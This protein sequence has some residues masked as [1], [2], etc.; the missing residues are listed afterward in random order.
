ML[1]PR[2]RAFVDTSTSPQRLINPDG[3]IIRVVANASDLKPGE[4]AIRIK[5]YPG[6]IAAKFQ[7]SGQV[8]WIGELPPKP[9]A[10][11]RQS[12]RDSL[13]FALE[14]GDDGR[15]GLRLPQ[16]G[17]VH[18][19]LGCWTTSST[20]PATVVMPTGT[21]KTETM[22]AL[23]AAGQLE[24]LLV[25]VPSDVLRTQIAAKFESLG[26]LQERGVIAVNAMRPVVGRL[27]QGFSSADAARSFVDAC[28]VVVTT[29]AAL[30]ASGP[31]A[32][33]TILSSFSHLFIDEAH[34]VEAAT[35]QRIRDSFAGKPIL[36]FTATPF[37]EDGRRL[38]GRIV[39]SYP[40]REAQRHGYFS[41]I[42]YVSIVDFENQDRAIAARAVEQLRAD[43]AAGLDHL[44]M[45]RVMRIG[46]IAD[47][48]QIYAE[49]APDF[50][51]V[52]LHSKLSKRERQSA[53]DR[54]SRRKSRI[55]ICVDML[56]E[57]FDLPSLKVA[58]IHDVHKS[59]GVTLQFIGRLARVAGADIGEAT[60]VAAR[61]EG[62]Y[63][64]NLRRLYSEDPD[65]NLII[66]DLSE[67]AVGQEDAISQF[68]AG[69]RAVP[70]EVT[71][72]N[73]EPKMSTVVY[74]TRCEIWRPQAISN[75][76]PE[77]S[78]LAQP[79]VNEL[80]HVAWFIV[81]AQT[82]V[83]WGQ[84]ETLSDV[85]YDLY[86]LY[87]DNN[88][89]LLY[90]NGS[91]N[92]SVFEDLAHAVCGPDTELIHGE[93]IYRVMAGI[94]RLVPTNVGL[95]DVRNRSR[96]F[97]M[98]VGADVTEGFPVAEAGTKTQ[99][100]IFAYGYENGTFVT[101]GG[102]LKGRIWS[103]RVARTIKHWRD[104]CDHIGAKV[105]DSR[106]SVD[107]VLHGFIRPI[108]LEARPRYVALGL[109]WTPSVYL[110]AS[111]AARVEWKGS[112]WPLLNVD[113]T[114]TDFSDYGPIRFDVVTP[115]WRV[116]YEITFDNGNMGY[117]AV[118]EEVEV[119]SHR[120]R[121][122]LSSYLAEHGL[123]V[124]LEQD[125]VVE[126]PGIL[127]KP[128]RDSPPFE[129][130]K[131]VVIDWAGVDLRKESQGPHR[132][133]DS[134]QARAAVYV[135]GLANWDL[136]MDDDG[137]GEI[138]DLV[139]MRIEG[140]LLLVTLV[141]CKY[142]SQEVA[143]SRVSDLYEVCGQ[144]QKSARWRNSM[145]DL[146]PALI[147]RERGRVRRSGTSGFM[148]GDPRVLYQL[149]DRSRFLKPE[150]HVLIVQPGLSRTKVSDVQLELLGSTEVYLRE[151][152]HASL[153]VLC[154]E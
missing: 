132:A 149:Q 129:P 33:D 77:D 61:P 91:N 5:G 16:L 64:E 68:E 18:A 62:L 22:I 23:L 26:I 70:E 25:V 19:V 102:S 57:G 90:I 114:I 6:D 153:Q 142:S 110:S 59:L 24:R 69:F 139:A 42:N 135:Q 136:L 20:E 72:R 49:L 146:F 28:N 116:G 46:R 21:G 122:P 89:Q 52:V 30:F 100:N 47:V 138:A 108:T 143:G 11:V 35:W 109:E 1:S 145:E 66:R 127:L 38:A 101:V 125:A 29:P 118:G 98:H 121:R 117:R 152:A 119:V 124:L 14:E 126:P 65:W 95:L 103:H 12:W 9:P 36:Q 82:A 51:P 71:L 37:R 44:L 56:G 17:A 76:F 147:G 141:H 54:I 7:E 113:L 87:W 31:G 93:V 134:V 4:R 43:I 106:I 8:Q 73:I 50:S 63:D 45:A 151:R 55:I 130:E 2:G 88:R 148:V 123:F 75:I 58:A 96:R 53:L 150:L 107:E 128:E 34:H 74:R 133:P 41:R 111:H 78:L 92:D 40:L 99:T 115:D 97:S 144:A 120:S 48:L 94:K 60:V 83:R 112:D 105:S 32:V 15:P 84:L 140:E 10:L 39:Y 104:W 81:K 79:S 13:R 154:S 131:L 67:V 137:P 85:S 86:V 80:E 27:K 3:E